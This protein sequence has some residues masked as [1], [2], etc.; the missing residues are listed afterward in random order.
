MKKDKKDCTGC[1]ACKTVCPRQCI[2]LIQDNEGFYYPEVDT[3]KC[4]NCG[5]CRRI[6]PIT[7]ARNESHKTKTVYAA[8]TNDRDVWQRSSS[9]GAFYEICKA[10]KALFCDCVFYGVTVEKEKVY[11]LRVDTL[12]G[13]EKFHKSK[14]VQSDLNDVFLQ[15]KSDLDKGYHV[16]FSGTPCQVAGLCRLTSKPTN[17][18]CIDFICHGVGSPAV[19]SSYIKEKEEERN[20]SLLQ[21]E[22]RSKSKS[23]MCIHTSYTSYT[24]GKEYYEEYDAYN[25]LFLS[26][27][28]IRPSCGV[29]CQF[30][31]EE[32]LSDITIADFK[33]KF[34]V[35]PKDNDKRS[36]STII[37]NSETGKK[38]WQ[39]MTDRMKYYQVSLDDIKKWNP[40]FSS[41]GTENNERDKF[42]EGFISGCSVTD[43]ADKY[44]TKAKKKSWINKMMPWSIKRILLKI[45]RL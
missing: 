9:G 39:L 23:N 1:T 37:I 2:K 10:A 45:A 11:H 14:Y 42:F 30:R 18:I 5:L 36:W 12:E 31:S 28:C 16:L 19:F 20:D 41:Q 43:L 29:N 40:L 25:R 3:D 38:L 22:F 8:I 26:Q 33:N 21:Y 34:E 27:L 24:S 35:L 6:C 17:L 44:T 13:V 32:R 4:V 15:V 7:P